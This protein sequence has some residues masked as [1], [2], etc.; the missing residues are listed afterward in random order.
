MAYISAWRT[1]LSENCGEEQSIGMLFTA[2]LEEMYTW[3]SP[4]S[5]RR[6]LSSVF[7]DQTEESASPVS[8]AI[9]RTDGSGTLSI[10]TASRC[11]RPRK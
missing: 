5:R 3:K 10:R 11:G 8:I 6:M 4:L 1:T 7:S 9:A 2:V